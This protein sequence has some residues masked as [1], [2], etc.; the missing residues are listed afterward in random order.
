MFAD[1]PLHSLVCSLLTLTSITLAA[2]ITDECRWS[3]YENGNNGNSGC[4]GDGGDDYWYLGRTQ[5][6]R[7]NVAYSLY[8][9]KPDQEVPSNPCA[10]SANY[11]NSLFTTG[12]IESFGNNVGVAY[13]NYG[14]STTCTSTF[15]GDAENQGEQGQQ[16]HN[17]QYYPDYT[18]T[19]LGCSA[20]GE[21]VKAS[22]Q[23][24]YCD[25]NHFLS[26][27]GEYTDL[28]SDLADVGCYQIYSYDNSDNSALSLLSYSSTCSH[29]EY[30][31]TCPDP[32]NMKRKR[33]QKFFQYAKGQNRAVPLIMPILS[34]IMLLA[35]AGLYVMANGVRDASKRRGLEAVSGEIIEPS[36]S[37]KFSL[38]MSRV[39]TDLSQRT[40]SFT[41]KIAEYAEAEEESTNGG[42]S[43]ATGGDYQ[44]PVEDTMSASPSLQDNDDGVA[45]PTTEQAA[46]VPATSATGKQYKRPRMARMSRFFRSRFG[47]CKNDNK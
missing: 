1:V 23:G 5:C 17:Q 9:I 42:A 31:K 36:I 3:E 10:S 15:V 24:A 4:S 22:F 11:I 13:G 35:A 32:H 2:L 16:G 39:G 12:G 26:N 44:A 29:T 40:R 43:A 6:F 8:G 25:G 18:S 7:A 33:D 41:E 20:S 30:P 27:D 19:T 34:T 47:I 14:V 28:N 37:E 21:F 38:R 45:A 46:A